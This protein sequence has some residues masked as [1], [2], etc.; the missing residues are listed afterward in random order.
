MDRRPGQYIS[1]PMR[2]LLS[3][4]LLIGCLALLVAGPGTALAQSGAPFAPLPQAQ[5]HNS[6]VATTTTATA[7]DDG[8]LSRFQ[9]T[10]IFLAGVALLA[11]IGFAIVGDAR[12]AAPVTEDDRAGA[13]ASSAAGA[14]KAHSKAKAR[15]KAKRARAA[16]KKNR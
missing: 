5:P 14:R 11:G 3:R 12:K 1:A 9:E 6:T 15:E 2:T 16:R 10:M 4:M 13:H 8:G 7:A